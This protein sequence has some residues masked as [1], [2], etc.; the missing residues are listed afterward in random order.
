MSYKHRWTEPRDRE[1]RAEY[2]AL[3]RELKNAR[4]SK[5]RRLEIEVCL[6]KIASTSLLASGTPS[7]LP[8]AKPSTKDLLALCG[9]VDDAKRKGS[10]SEKSIP[11]AEE[12]LV[13][14]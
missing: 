9:R 14:V 7:E 12:I 2:R 1:T 3:R 5:P 6:D 13:K 10:L 4:T 11:S 8:P